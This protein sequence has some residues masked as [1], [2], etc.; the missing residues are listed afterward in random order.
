MKSLCLKFEHFI[1]VF[2]KVLKIISYSPQKS[3][4]SLIPVGGVLYARQI[5]PKKNE[6][7]IH[8]MFS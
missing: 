1:F 7:T 2:L 5:G 6:E 8:F 4:H 3:L